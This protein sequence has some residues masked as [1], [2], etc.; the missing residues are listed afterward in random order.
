MSST[1]VTLITCMVE[2]R[3][4]EEIRERNEISRVPIVSRPTRKTTM[5]EVPKTLPKSLSVFQR[6]HLEP[7]FSNFQGQRK[8]LGFP[9]KRTVSFVCFACSIQT[10]SVPFP[11]TFLFDQLAFANATVAVWSESK[12][13]QKVNT[14]HPKQLQ[15]R[16]LR[17][18][19]IW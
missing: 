11:F 12:T 7:S 18:P 15:Q 16:I 1:A 14:T 9:N 5:L 8:T 10:V 13:C 4:G 17:S 3:T 6:T 2:E 19:L